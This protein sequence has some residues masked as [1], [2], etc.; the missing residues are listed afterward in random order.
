MTLESDNSGN[1]Y[2]ITRPEN[3]WDFSDPLIQII[4]L[5]MVRYAVQTESGHLQNVIAYLTTPEADDWTE[6]MV[7]VSDRPDYEIML[8][9]Y[10]AV[11]RARATGDSDED[12]RLRATQKLQ[13]LK[14]WTVED[15]A[16]KKARSAATKAQLDTIIGEYPSKDTRS[17]VAKL[18]DR[19]IGK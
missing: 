4:E 17:P 12:I 10:D 2:S 14:D 13:A 8:H 18:I 11:E 3:L 7:N 5:D 15:E 19:L 1:E 9:T 6:R 16:I